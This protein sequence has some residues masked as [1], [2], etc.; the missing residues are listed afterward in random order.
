MALLHLNSWAGHT[1]HKCEIVS[2]TRKRYRI[3]L[4][5][6]CLK[7]DKGAILSVPK[8]AQSFPELDPPDVLP[9]K[10]IGV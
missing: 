3:K 5:E 6:K 8:S 1:A 10:G 2:T 4:L 7:G 9:K